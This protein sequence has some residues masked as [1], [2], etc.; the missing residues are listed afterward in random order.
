MNEVHFGLSASMFT[1]VGRR[2][3]PGLRVCTMPLGVPGLPGAAFWTDLIGNKGSSCPGMMPLPSMVDCSALVACG[4]YDNRDGIMIIS[5]P[6]KH[7]HDP[8]QVA[9]VRILWSGSNRYLSTRR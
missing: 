7:K 9:L 2:P 6:G 5:A 4:V 1:G 8:P 3:D